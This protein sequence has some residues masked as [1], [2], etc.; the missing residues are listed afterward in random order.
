LK[1][2]INHFTVLVY[3]PPEIMLLAVDLDEYF[4][5]VKGVAE[6]SVPSLQATGIN[7]TEF[8]AP[9]TDRFAADGDT[10][11]REKVFDIAVSEVESMVEPDGKGNDVRWESM[12]FVGI[13][14]L[15]LPRSAR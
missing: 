5:D 1:I 10:A 2:H 14:P 4:I 9:E 7:R 11:F 3:G 6:T 8:N 12:A 15:R 13:H